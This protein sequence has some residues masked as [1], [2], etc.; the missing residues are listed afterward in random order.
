MRSLSIGRFLHALLVGALVLCL[1]DQVR[2]QARAADAPA[3]RRVAVIGDAAATGAGPTAR[4]D[5]WPEQLGRALGSAYAVR[6]FVR[7]NTSVDPK[8]PRFVR[9]L[10]EWNWLVDFAPETVVIALGSADAMTV[11]FPAASR[12]DAGMREIVE[13]MQALPTAP[14]IFVCLP[15]VCAPS[16]PRAA[17]YRGNRTRV[18]EAWTRVAGAMNLTAIDLDPALAGHEASL[19]DGVA[20]DALAAEAVAR[21]VA[22]A[23]LAADGVDGE[24]FLAGR[25]TMY[26]PNAALPALGRTRVVDDGA[27]VGELRGAESWKRDGGVLVGAPRGATLAMDLNAGDRPFRWRM[28]LT[29]EG[30]EGAAAQLFLDEQYFVLENAARQ[31]ALSG[32]LFRGKPV[33]GPAIDL[34]QRGEEFEIEVRRAGHDIE[35]LIDGKVVFANPAGGWNCR[36]IALIPMESTVR[37]RSWTVEAGD[38]SQ[39]PPPF[40][41]LADREELQVVIDRREGQ[42]LGHPSTV[43]LDD[44]KTI[45]LAY[46]L[47]HGRGAI[48]FRRSEDGGVTWSEPL[49]TPTNWATSLETP[50]LHRLS[51]PTRGGAPRHV[52]FSGLHPTRIASSEDNGVTWTELAAVPTTGEKSE[53]WGGIVTMS[54]VIET[55]DG[56]ALAFFHDDGRFFRPNGRGTGVS[57]VYATDSRDGGRIWSAPRAILSRERVFLCEPGVVRSPDGKRLVMLLRENNRVANSFLSISDDDGA[58]WSEPRELPWWLTGDRHVIARLKDGRFL[59]TMRDMARS[60]PTYGDWVAWIGSW[61]DLERGDRGE[62]RIRLMNNFDGTDCGY[63]GLEVLP[64]GTVVATSYGHWVEGQQP[65]IVSVRIPA[66]LLR[67]LGTDA[68]PDDGDDASASSPSDEPDARELPPA[69]AP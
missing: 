18:I 23:I 30:G 33:V 6:S 5:A 13:S 15:P 25:S 43:L 61:E 64:D 57:T 37:L 14:R 32:E 2:G 20:A 52:L 36:T 21:S 22:L 44:G 19:K 47:G 39:E 24:S 4:L 51:D 40:V 16:W 11:G 8:S 67:T 42:Y 9:T 45:L 58:T 63:A 60:S 50:T 7:Q 53:P 29:I 48:V 56:R 17:T 62:A 3:L 1:A 66:A 26:R 28:R 55:R 65:F 12:L 69:D 41:D 49:P 38:P 46:P 34:W 35:F 68:M 27:V 31:V 54:S 10:P 59:V